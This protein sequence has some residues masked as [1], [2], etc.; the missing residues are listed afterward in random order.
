MITTLAAHLDGGNL[1]E[2]IVERQREIL[3]RY[4]IRYGG[5]VFRLRHRRP[6]L[7]RHVLRGAKA[8]LLRMGRIVSSCRRLPSTRAAIV[9]PHGVTETHTYRDEPSC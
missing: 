8:W 1:P 4:A 7:F 5:S 3:H 9:L 6:P 2:L